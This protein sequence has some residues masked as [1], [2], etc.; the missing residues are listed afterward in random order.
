MAE[1]MAESEAQAETQAPFL[2][3]HSSFGL[4]YRTI[5]RHL[6]G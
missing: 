3:G 6:R 2:I 5:R 1:S 4:R